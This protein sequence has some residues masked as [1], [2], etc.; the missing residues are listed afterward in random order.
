M[1][2]LQY[3]FVSNGVIEKVKQKS[4]ES[5]SCL[6]NFFHNQSQEKKIIRVKLIEFFSLKSTYTL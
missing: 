4:V 1:R 3:W 6:D 5:R 2:A